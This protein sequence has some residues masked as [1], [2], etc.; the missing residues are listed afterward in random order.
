MLPKKGFYVDIGCAHPFDT[1]NT[2]FLRDLGW[3][4]LA[5]DGNS[6]WRS[7]WECIK[8]DSEFIGWV[9]SNRVYEQFN[10][11]TDEPW[12]SRIERGGSGVPTVTCRNIE[13]IL[14][15]RHVRKIDF[16]SVD[17]EGSEFDVISS[18]DLVFHDPTIIVSEYD[19]RDI[20]KD[21][22][23]RDYLIEQGYCIRHTTESN[24]I[25]TK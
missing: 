16:L 13:D 1:S 6:I 12:L 22:R 2:A 10:S 15:E 21:Y 8:R 11:R 24:M 3:T 19:T 17:V 23:V 9:I 5:I 7:H 25:Y 18:I 4:G 14:S 20:G